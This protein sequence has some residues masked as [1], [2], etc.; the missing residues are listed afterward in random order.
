MYSFLFLFPFDPI[1]IISI[2]AFKYFPLYLRR[3]GF[4][5]VRRKEVG[6]ETETFKTF[7]RCKDRL[8]F[9]NHPLMDYLDYLFIN[10]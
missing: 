8:S 1:A 10:P 6:A 2:T 3:V 4:V 7:Y 9:M 5:E